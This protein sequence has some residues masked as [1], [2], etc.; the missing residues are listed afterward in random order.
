MDL[1]SWISA[2]ASL[3]RWLIFRL[4]LA[5]SI[6]FASISALWIFAGF[7]LVIRSLIKPATQGLIA[8]FEL[9][10]ILSDNLRSVFEASVVILLFSAGPVLAYN[11]SAFTNWVLVRSKLRAI[12]YS[13][14]SPQVPEKII[15]LEPDLFSN[16][17]KIGIVLAGGG[18]RA[19]FQAGAMKAIYQLLGEHRALEK[20]K[21]I[22]ST[23][24]GSWNA[25]FWLADLIMPQGGWNGRGVHENW[26]RS[27]S[28]KS[29]IAPSWYI[30]FFRNCFLSPEPWRQVFDHL[31]GREDVRERLI[32]TKIHFYMTRSNIGAG[33]LDCVTNNTAPPSIARVRYEIAHA[34]EPDRFL[35]TI[36]CGVFA[37][38]DMPPLFPYSKIE[39]RLFEDGGV[40]DNLPITF[41]ALEGCDL[42]FIL[43]LNADFEADINQRSLVHRFKRVMDV[44]QGA[45]ERSGF[46]LVYLYNEL[47]ALRQCLEGAATS[48]PPEAALDPS[49]DSFREAT[50]LDR[51]L[52]RRNR[53]INVFAVCPNKQFVD[54]S[55]DTYEIWKAEEAGIAFEVMYD[56]TARLLRRCSF[57]AP[58]NTVR[59]ALISRNGSV[60]WDENF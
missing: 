21:V 59:M 26:W 51:A 25:L 4:P 37:S 36:K 44:R 47:A 33:E 46:K 8:Y 5:F 10:E 45:L 9:P 3:I 16:V 41:P 54:A 2:A 20:V 13:D 49:S 6:P 22:S 15:G 60:L 24:T 14:G 39:N 35:D 58:Q 43:P 27:I 31:F 52:A 55:I 38:M 29:L 30:P 18:A 12:P 19:A 32:S 40:I 23:S 48:R 11:L 34:D 28:V 50:P 57:D 42:I 17:E 7:P 53:H 56:S 1:T